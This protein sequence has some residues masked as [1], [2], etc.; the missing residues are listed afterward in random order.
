MVQNSVIR[1]CSNDI[2]ELSSSTTKFIGCTFSG[3]DYQGYSVPAFLV[4][5]GSVTLDSCTFKD[6][7]NNKLYGSWDESTVGTWTESNCT[8]TGNGWQ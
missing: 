6:N 7:Q 2:A 3:N 1:D 4:Y 8:Y 5:Q